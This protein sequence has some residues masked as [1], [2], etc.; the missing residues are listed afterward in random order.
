MLDSQLSV[1]DANN[2][3][4]CQR[5]IIKKI[6]KVNDYLF[7]ILDNGQKILTDGKKLYDCSE[8]THFTDIF[9]MG[10]KLC[11]VFRDYYNVVVVDLNKMEVLFKD[12]EAYHV[13]KQDERTLNVIKHIGYGNKTIYDVETKK[14]LPMPL[15]YEFEHSLGNNLYVFREEHNSKRKFFDCKRCVINAEGKFILKGIEGW[16]YYSNNHLIIIKEDELCIVEL[17]EQSALNIKTIKKEGDIIAKP[18]YY[19]GNILVIE[20]GAIKVYTPDFVLI[21]EL[22]I[23]E[24]QEVDDYELLEDTLK[25]ALPYT[26]N[27]KK[28]GRHLFVNLKTGKTISHLRIEGYPYWAPTT[29]IGQD[30]LD[31]EITEFHFY[32]A[33]FEPIISV[34]GN[35]YESIE[36]NR[37]C[38]FTIISE[39]NGVQKQQLLNSETGAIREVDYNYVHFHM[40]LPYGY[41]VNFSTGKMDFFDENLNVIIPG[42]D[43]KKFNIGY[44]YTDFSYF[45][46][47]DYV[48]VT[49]HI[50]DGPR[51]YYRYIIQKAS[52]EI[53][54][55]SMEYTCFPMGNLI[56]IF[57]DK[58]SRFLNTITGE[59]GV[60]SIATPNNETGKIDFKRISDFNSLLT[61]EDGTQLS[62]PS[63][64]SDAIRKTRK[65]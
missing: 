53:I 17:N 47:N 18:K 30:S 57:N 6:E 52:G 39:K 42:F 48:C 45:I 62:L 36:C 41:G 29:F 38:M 8:Y 15:E 59:I 10:D 44:Q 51:S 32:N 21:N 54:L 60:L 49:K 26:V 1:N 50:A 20:K 23:D 3:L 24:L 12:G 11:A 9:T 61:M 13:S 46:V 2:E 4:G 65:P 27:E 22:F 16:I 40:S 25:I 35:Y 58:G 56:Q 28:I 33:N 14:Y 55:D 34:M 37:E 31:S 5:I 7:I 19:D 64:N 63:T 43:Y